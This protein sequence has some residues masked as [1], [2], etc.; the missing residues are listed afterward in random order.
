VS[1]LKSAADMLFHGAVV[2]PATYVQH[3]ISAPGRRVEFTRNTDSPVQPLSA[4]GSVKVEAG[5]IVQGGNLWAPFGQ[6]EF[7]A[8]GL[9]AFRDGS[10]TSVAAS[11]G[12]L[13][14]FGRLVN[15]QDWVYAIGSRLF[16]QKTLAGKSIRIDGATVDMQPGAKMNLAGGGDLQGY[17]FTVGPGGSRDILASFVTV[18]EKTGP[19]K[20]LRRSAR[21]PGRLRPG[22]PAGRL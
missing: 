6:T 3:T 18:D 1:T 9:V 15:G 10:L 7:K 16:E 21:V 5:D 22:R 17:E 20:Y 8:T 13:T 12:S 2:T 4:F 19:H 14:P 11:P